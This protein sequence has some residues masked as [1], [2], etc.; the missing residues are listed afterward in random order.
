MLP[1]KIQTTMRLR[2]DLVEALDKEAKATGLSRTAMFEQ[3]LAK[4]LRGR[5]YK[6]SVRVSL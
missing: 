1:E 5:G 4:F 3:I 2:R 6:L